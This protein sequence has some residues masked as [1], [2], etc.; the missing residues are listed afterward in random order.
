MQHGSH[1]TYI[2]VESITPHL[3][4]FVKIPSRLV[5][6]WPGSKCTNS[7]CTHPSR[8]L[9]EWYDLEHSTRG[10][11]N[12]GIISPYICITVGKLQTKFYHF[13]R[14]GCFS[15]GWRLGYLSQPRLFLSAF[16]QLCYSIALPSQL[17]KFSASF[18]NWLGNRW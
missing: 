2:S 15:Q 14:L 17:G 8:S 7:I 10:D 18:L 9:Q 1:F 5:P 3:Y 13:I 4:A 6:S 12:V 11:A 16:A